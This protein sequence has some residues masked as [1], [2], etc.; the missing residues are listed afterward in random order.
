MF[1][2]TLD[3]MMTCSPNDLC[4]EGRRASKNLVALFAAITLVLLAATRPA[5]ASTDAG[6]LEQL[7]AARGLGAD[8]KPETIYPPAGVEVR[9]Y[10]QIERDGGRALVTYKEWQEPLGE[11]VLLIDSSTY[12][13]GQSSLMGWLLSP[14]DNSCVLFR[15]VE[16]NREHRQIDGGFWRNDPGLRLAGAHEFPVDLYPDYT[17]SIAPIRALGAPGTGA[18]GNFHSQITPYGYITIDVWSDDAADLTV[19]AGTFRA[20]KVSARADIRS[21]LPSWPTLVVNVIQPFI[22]SYSMYFEARPPYR[23]LRGEGQNSFGGP[24][25]TTELQRYY[26]A[27][28]KA[29]TDTSKVANR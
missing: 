28:A 23:F 17:P 16:Y 9:E 20:M 15:R 6:D 12:P 19:N 3:L 14:R 21:F 22:H 25:V 1:T 7:L 24:E 10:S 8:S 11:N 29:D 26:T 13:D 2:T 4:N 18:K 5:L 27:G